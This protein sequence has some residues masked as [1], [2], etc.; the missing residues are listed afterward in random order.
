[1]L[2]CQ[3]ALTHDPVVIRYVHL[4]QSELANRIA[5]RP[6]VYPICKVNFYSDETDCNGIG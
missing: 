6:R 3:S 2:L 1:M 5:N 4:F